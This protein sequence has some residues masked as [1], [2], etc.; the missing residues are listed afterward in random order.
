M[1]IRLKSNGEQLRAVPCG[2]K[3]WCQ[4]QRYAMKAFCTPSTRRRAQWVAVLVVSVLFYAYL[5]AAEVDSWN[6]QIRS[7]WAW[8]DLM[9]ADGG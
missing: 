3:A 1:A 2:A 9:G 4:T 7:L 5:R 6:R 8:S